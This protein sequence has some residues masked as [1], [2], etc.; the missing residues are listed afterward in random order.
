[1]DLYGC[2]VLG[3]NRP[4]GF[5]IWTLRLNSASVAMDKRQA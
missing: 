4:T 3:S 5:G 1:M 2:I